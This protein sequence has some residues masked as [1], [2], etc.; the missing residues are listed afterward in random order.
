MSLHY[1]FFCFLLYF[2]VFVFVF[3]AANVLAAIGG[4][5]YALNS[6][7]LSTNVADDLL[8][9]VIVSIIIGGVGSIK[10]CL[11]GAILVALTHN[12]MNGIFPPL[13]GAVSA[14][15]LMIAILLWCPHGL[16]PVA[17]IK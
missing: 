7:T 6:G 12:Y 10:G 17:S 2:F 3:V 11:V 16:N 4:S 13:S 15:L 8:L 5:V 9:V 1:I 14:V